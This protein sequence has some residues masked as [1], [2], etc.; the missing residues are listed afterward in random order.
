M[1]EGFSIAVALLAMRLVAGIL[2]FFQGYDKLFRVRTTGVLFAFSDSL[3]EKKI[4]IPVV[5]V[6]ITLS[7]VIELVGG[8]LLALGL[9]RDP[10]LY[11][12]MANMVCVAFAF[13]VVKPM[14]DLGYFF[15]RF[16]LLVALLLLPPSCDW[17]CLAQLF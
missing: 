11:L 17:F 5:R 14:W 4:P 12:L 8:L 1:P 3:K 13:S 2:F 16:V 10:V 7:S 15:P 9:F 6:F